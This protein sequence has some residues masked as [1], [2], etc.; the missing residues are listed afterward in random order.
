MY[1]FHSKDTI[2]ACGSLKCEIVYQSVRAQ[3]S[4]KAFFSLFVTNCYNTWFGYDLQNCKNVLFGFGL[5]DQEYVFKNNVY[6]KK[7]WEKIFQ[8][9]AQKIKTISGLREVQQE[10]EI[11]KNGFPHEATHRV[12]VE[13]SR[14]TQIN[15]SKNMIFGFAAEADQDSWYCGTQGYSQNVMDVELSSMSQLAYNCVGAVQLY[16]CGCIGS[17][18]GE[19]RDSYYLF[20]TRG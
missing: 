13:D 9:Y 14:G 20:Y 15:N 2:D 6:S 19:L 10:Y 5:R 11:F 3:N 7:E 1:D 16:S 4:M 18:F 8:E 17:N 12:R